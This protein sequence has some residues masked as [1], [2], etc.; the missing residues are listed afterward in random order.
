GFTGA[1]SG[2]TKSAFTI[3][4]SKDSENPFLINRTLVPDLMHEFELGVWKSIFVHLIRMLETEGSDVVAEFNYRFRQVGSFGVDT[5]RKFDYDVSEMKGFTAHDF[6]DALQ[7]CAPCFSGLFSQQSNEIQ[8]LIFV[9]MKWH[10]LAKLYV[11]TDMTLQALRLA[12]KLLGSRLRHFR[13]HIAPLYHTHETQKE[14]EKRIRQ[15]AKVSNIQPSNQMATPQSLPPVGKKQQIIEETQDIVL[16]ERTN[17]TKRQTKSFSL[18]GFKIHGLGDI[19]EAIERYGTTESY[20]TQISEREHRSVKNIFDRTSYIDPTKQMTKLER[21]ESHLRNRGEELE[22]LKKNVLGDKTSQDE[23]QLEDPLHWGPS[24]ERYDISEKGT[25]IRIGDFLKEHEG[26]PAITN[27]VPKLQTH[28]LDR[29]Q[30]SGSCSIGPEEQ[31]LVNFSG[32][33]LYKHNLI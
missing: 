19:I 2:N 5:I 33:K 10:F 17:H 25:P 20:S 8:T 13:D 3:R 12:T 6:E 21:R 22:E 16:N 31:S 1:N 27:F 32:G 30:E 28:A 18:Q 24:S 11:H 4:L 23:T 7:C 9:L 14:Y 26:D 29:V 15:K